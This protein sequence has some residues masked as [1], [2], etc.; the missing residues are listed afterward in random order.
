VECKHHAEICRWFVLQVFPKHEKK[1]A[2]IL[3]LKGYEYFLPLCRTKRVWSDR[4]VT[5]DA[6]LFPGYVFCQMKEESARDVL[7]TAGVLRIVTFGGRLCPVPDAEI[8][9]L[10]IVVNKA[11]DPQPWPHMK[12]GDRV[13]IKSGPFAGVVGYLTEIRNQKRLVVSVDI[14]MKSISVDVEGCA[15]APIE[16]AA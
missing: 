12:I 2:I 11:R 16:S 14:I 6:P 1:V 4:V 3:N 5:I 9:D 8:Q 10:Q 13:Q 7:G 15:F